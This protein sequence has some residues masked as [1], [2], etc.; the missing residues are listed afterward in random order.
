VLKCMKPCAELT[1]TNHAS[2]CKRYAHDLF[3]KPTQ[4]GS[5]DMNGRLA[6]PVCP[7]EPP[8]CPKEPPVCPKEPPVCPKEPPA[9]PVCRPLPAGEKMY[10][11]VQ[12]DPGTL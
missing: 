11:Q 12:F 1:F 8:V 6:P 5:W 10:N 7:K 3:N 4:A 2:P 9:P